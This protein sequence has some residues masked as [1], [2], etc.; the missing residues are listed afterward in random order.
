MLLLAFYCVVGCWVS[1]DVGARW[2]HGPGVGIGSGMPENRNV[3]HASFT[4]FVMFDLQE[5]ARGE[6]EELIL[7]SLESHTNFPDS[8][9]LKLFWYLER[10]SHTPNQIRD[11]DISN[12]RLTVRNSVQGLFRDTHTHSHPHV[13]LNCDGNY[14]ALGKV[15]H[16]FIINLAHIQPK[17]SS[18]GNHDSSPSPLARFLAM[19]L[20]CGTVFLHGELTSVQSQLSFR[21]QL[22]TFLFLSSYSEFRCYRRFRFIAVININIHFL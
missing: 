11:I 10:L 17:R 22:E 1:V 19:V 8:C 6:V 20:I 9:P 18:F 7:V 2:G 3:E 12:E 15:Y 4:N 13:G 14:D 5:R 21:Y 16:T